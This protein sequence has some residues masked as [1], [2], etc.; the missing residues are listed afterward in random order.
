MTAKE[1]LLELVEA[2]SEEWAERVLAVAKQEAG[3]PQESNA[4]RLAEL[5]RQFQR[6]SED[7]SDEELRAY[8][9]LIAN[10]APVG[11]RPVGQRVDVQ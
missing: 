11:F 6:E 1:E 5:V 10:L 8:D 3:P 2:P 4:G 9:E 7:V